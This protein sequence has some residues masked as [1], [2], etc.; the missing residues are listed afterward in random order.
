MANLKLVHYG[1]CMP[2]RTKGRALK[3]NIPSL[4]N[5]FSSKSMKQK[6]D[7]VDFWEIFSCRE[8]CAEII[9]F[10][11]IRRQELRRFF[12]FKVRLSEIFI[13]FAFILFG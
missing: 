8:I 7:F 6:V 2:L 5:L 4:R 3:L 9:H 11:K 10:A 13:R 12:V 1:T